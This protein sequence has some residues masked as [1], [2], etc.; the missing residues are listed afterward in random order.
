MA[1][2]TIGRHRFADLPG[3]RLRPRSRPG[4]TRNWPC[5]QGVHQP[6]NVCRAGQ[7]AALLTQD[8]VLRPYCANRFITACSAALSAAVTMSWLPLLKA[9]FQ[10]AGSH[11]RDDRGRSRAGGGQCKSRQ[12]IR[13]VGRSQRYSNRVG[14]GRRAVP[15]GRSGPRTGMPALLWMRS[16]VL[17]R[18]QPNAFAK[19]VS[20]LPINDG[21]GQ[22]FPSHGGAPRRSMRPRP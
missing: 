18:E 1:G 10:R 14:F 11:H 20:L 8:R 7:A 15:A 4:R 2:R 9:E 12:I 3:P 22:G 21:C 17:L 13:H 19:Q 5:V 6:L 16:G